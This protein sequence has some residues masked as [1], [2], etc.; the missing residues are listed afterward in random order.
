MPSTWWVRNKAMRATLL[1]LAE[2]IAGFAILAP[3]QEGYP[4]TGTWH[5]SW[6]PMRKTAPT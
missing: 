4:L 5:G 2:L 3:A 1:Y 6:V